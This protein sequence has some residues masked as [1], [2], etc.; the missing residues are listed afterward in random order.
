MEILELKEKLQD[1]LSGNELRKVLD[2]LKEILKSGTDTHNN[3]ILLRR[4]FNDMMDKRQTNTISFDNEQ[5]ESNKIAIAL[6]DCIQLLEQKDL[7]STSVSGHKDINAPLLVLTDK[8]YLQSI[9]DLFKSLRLTNTSVL[10]FNEDNIQYEGYDLIIFNNTDLPFCPSAD[11]LNKMELTLK[12]KIDNR[13]ALMKHVLDNTPRFL[14]HFGD[15][16][17]WLNNH[18][19]RIHAANSKFS[20]YARIKEMLDYIDTYRV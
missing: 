8:E 12:Q 4:R 17:F 11:A 20:L 18:R 14:I 9:T 7:K 5:I 10:S 13:T 1:Q 3:F 16:L 6:L 15:L 19:D 2:T